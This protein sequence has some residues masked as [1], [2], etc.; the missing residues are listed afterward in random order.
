MAKVLVT[1]ANGFVG[2]A[3]ANHL[4]SAGYQVIRAVRQ[5]DIPNTLRVGDVGPNTEWQSALDGCDWVV[6]LAARVHVM[7]EIADDSLALF[8]T[9]NTEGTLNL[10]R[11]AAQQGVQRFVYLSSIKVNGETGQFSEHSKALPQDAYAV[12]K[13]EAEQGLLQ[14][15][16]DTGME[17]VILRPPLIYGPGVGGNFIRLMC[18]VD[19]QVPMLVGLVTNRR[20]LLYLG[21]LV[22]AIATCLS[23]P[24]ASGKTYLVSDDEV[25]STPELIQKIS[26][27][28]GHSSRLLPCPPVLLRFGAWLFGKSK[29]VDRLLGSLECDSALIR[30]ELGWSPATSLQKGL[31]ITADWYRL[32]GGAKLRLGDLKPRICFVMTSPFTYGAFIAPHMLN[33]PQDFA[34]TVSFNREES[35]IPS[36]IPE[37][38]RFVSMPIIRNIAPL[39]DLFAFWKYYVFFRRE[40]FAIV[41]SLTPKG[42]VVAMLASWLARVPVRVHCFTGQVWATRRGIARFAL[43]AIDRVLAVAATQILADSESQKRFLVNEGVVSETKVQVLGAGSICGVD[44]GRFRPDPEAREKIRTELSLSSDDVC[45]VFVGRMKLEKGVM[46]LVSAFRKLLPR[47]PNLRLILVGPDEEGLISTLDELKRIHFVGYSS[48]A[49]EY[50]AASDILCLPSYR[51]GF[52][53]VLIEAGACGLPVVASAIYGVT[54]AVVDNETG[55]LY[56][57]HDVDSLAKKIEYLLENPHSR[58]AMGMAGRRR[59]LACF[60]QTHVCDLYAKYLRMAMQPESL[61]GLHD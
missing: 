35:S 30:T 28:L 48:V 46:D 38:V 2:C 4:E 37:G 52:G 22:G 26:Q 56:P 33:L 3:L 42:G 29:E 18:A 43:Q 19:R 36:R 24:R 55:L 51:E 31:Q 45:L 14:I 47:Y 32:T 41:F 39:R 1:G 53:S 40:K 17:I 34:V 50:M 6:H 15:G 16:A 58:I 60:N 5:P 7:H 44:I 54:D 27:A 49:N 8:R 59:V 61:S 57:P 25:V 23:H 11:Q 10:A 9:V 13:W 20:S 12:S 21:N